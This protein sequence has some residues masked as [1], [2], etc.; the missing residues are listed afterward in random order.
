MSDELH[1][2]PLHLDSQYQI[3]LQH[4]NRLYSGPRPQNNEI[5]HDKFP[6]ALNDAPHAKL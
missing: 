5:K 3:Y 4:E 1:L 6:G 2:D